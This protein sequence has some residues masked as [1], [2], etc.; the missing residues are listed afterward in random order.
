VGSSNALQEEPRFIATTMQRA[1][2][3]EEIYQLHNWLATQIAQIEPHY[4]SRPA[5]SW[6]VSMFSEIHHGW[7]A[8][9]VL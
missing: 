6:L 1:L 8:F 7:L 5:R 3:C 4:N 9:E 2:T